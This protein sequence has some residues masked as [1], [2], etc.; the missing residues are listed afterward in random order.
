MPGSI[1]LPTVVSRVAAAPPGAPAV[2]PHPLQRVWRALDGLPPLSEVA[3]IRGGISCSLSRREIA[4]RLVSTTPRPGF[5]GGLLR[6]EDGFEPLIVRGYLYVNMADEEMCRQA[7][8]LDWD[9]PKVIVNGVRLGRG[10]WPI[11]GAPDWE[12]T[13]ISQRFHALWP[14]GDLP[15]DVLAALL[16]GPVANA[17]LSAHGTTRDNRIETLARVPTPRFSPAPVAAIH[18]AVAEYRSAR[19]EWVAR[20]SDDATLEGV[21]RDALYRIDAELL[22]AYDLPPRVERELLDSFAGH[23]RPGPVAFDRYFPEG[24]RPALP[25]RMYVSGVIKHAGAR[26]TLQRLPVFRD[27]ALSEM[28]ANLG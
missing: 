3:D 6:V 8:A 16:N 12:G 26:A 28:V 20:S 4:E 9:R 15:I 2:L 23:R 7:Q 13:M 10:P 27:A 11:T 17:Y 1:E 22:A 24:F 19:A 18:A 25:W 5:R 21:C 14:H